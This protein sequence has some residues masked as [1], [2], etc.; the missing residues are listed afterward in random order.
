MW[1]WLSAEPRDVVDLA[2]AGTIAAADE[3]PHL[4]EELH[5]WR[6]IVGRRRL[7]V[8]LRRHLAAALVL[9]A[10]LEILAQ[11]GAFPQWVVIA[12]PLVLF[13]ASVTFFA[14]RGPSPF[15]LARLLDEELGLNDRLATA[16]EIEARG[17]AGTPLEARTV[18]DAAALLR[19]GR[20][21]WHASAAPADRDWWALAVPIVAI[22]AVVG[23]GSLASSGNSHSGPETALGPGGGKGGAAAK[24]R[25]RK[26]EKEE[27]KQPQA[28]TGKLH[29][30]HGVTKRPEPA[31]SRIAK[32]GYQQIPQ[33]YKTKGE[34]V[35]GKG[36]AGSGKT[37]GSKAGGKAGK[38][39]KAAG[40]KAGANEGGK[41]SASGAGKKEKE[42]PTVG[43]NVKGQ[44]KGGQGRPGTSEVSGA[45]NKPS[46]PN[47]QQDESSSTSSE[48]SKKGLPAGAGKAGGEQGN[49][50]QGHVTP[51][52]GQANKAV[53]IQPGYAPSRSNKGG[54]EHKKPGTQEGGGGKAR[55]AQVTGA[56]QVG[57]EFSFVPAAGGAVPGAG[58][59]LQQN[60]TESLKWVERLPW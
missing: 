20:E 29:K 9:A 1:R 12:V 59:G 39:H 3:R 60:Y 34:E 7:V 50:S 43:F 8:L 5:R 2:G 46:A 28:P 15:G 32:S 21:D 48:G 47:G 41:Q 52:K 23:V 35:S 30:I 33:G 40:G 42:H 13:V 22:A 17:G 31:A 4:G 54:K 10:L 51:V 14:L 57:D 56:T 27:G 53:K 24:E 25:R 58:P 37:N 16:L 36:E 45:G 49:N 6:R 44:N 19:A 11:L 18:G 26:R 38:I 55:T